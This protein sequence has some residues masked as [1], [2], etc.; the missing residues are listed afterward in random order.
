M[1]TDMRDVRNVERVTEQITRLL[2]LASKRGSV[3][4]L[5]PH[6]NAALYSLSILLVDFWSSVSVPSRLADP[7]DGAA[8]LVV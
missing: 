8:L 3:L 4:D 2:T 6:R 1:Q 7:L 5:R